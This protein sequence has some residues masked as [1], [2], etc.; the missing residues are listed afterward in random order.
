MS[1]S[2]M[3]C[4]HRVAGQ[5]VRNYRSHETL[6]RLPNSLFY[7]H[8]LLAAADQ[9]L[10]LPPAWAV[11]QLEADEDAVEGEDDTWMD[12]TDGFALDTDGFADG[13]GKLV[14]QGRVECLIG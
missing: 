13:E 5:L 1:D 8:T 14:L 4:L 11:H 7:N 10:L 12:D 9:S 3:I 2:H 6:L